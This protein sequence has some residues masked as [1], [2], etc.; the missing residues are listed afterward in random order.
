MSHHLVIMLRRDVQ[1]REMW[2]DLDGLSAKELA[3][4]IWANQDYFK[5]ED[6]SITLTEVR[7]ERS[8]G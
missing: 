2:F 3:E 8:E 1:P 4:T 5:R 6:W 7:E